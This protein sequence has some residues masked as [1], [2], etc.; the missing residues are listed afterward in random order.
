MT[1]E[2][3]DWLPS[4]VELN[5]Y[6]GDWNAYLEAVYQYFVQDFVDNKPVFCG[7]RLGL[8]RYPIEQGKEA[9]FWHMT[10]EGE[11]EAE[12]TP[13][14]RR[15]ERIRWPKPVIETAEEKPETTRVKLW[16]NQRR[17]NESRILLWVEA[18]NY[19]VVLADRGN[20]LLPW[21]AYLV[22]RAHQREKLQREYE[23]YWRSAGG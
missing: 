15:M 22:E 4:L 23:R 16:R 13:D 8:K 21:T 14:I 5:D 3:G 20:Y 17:G 2:Q 7:R 18:E 10:S 6:N 12:R 11:T 9:T 1:A 19:L